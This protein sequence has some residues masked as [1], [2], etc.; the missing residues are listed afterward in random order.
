MDV[1]WLNFSN[2]FKHEGK[3]KKNMK[4]KN[5]EFKWLELLN[6]KENVQIS[7]IIFLTI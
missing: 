6:M 3:N 2:D 5:Y 4:H 1:S 7:I